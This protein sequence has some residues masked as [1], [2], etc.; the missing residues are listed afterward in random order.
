M[1]NPRP[2]AHPTVQGRCPTCRRESLFL[3]AGG[4]VTCRRLECPQPM[5]ATALLERTNAPSKQPAAAVDWS[6]VTLN[7]KRL[8]VLPAPDP[9]APLRAVA[10]AALG[11]ADATAEHRRSPQTAADASGPDAPRAAPDAR[12]SA[13]HPLAGVGQRPEGEIGAHAG[14]QSPGPDTCRARLVNYHAQWACDRPAGHPGGHSAGDRG[15]GAYQAWTDQAAGAAVGGAL[16]DQIAEAL[17]TTPTKLLDNPAEQRGP[18]LMHVHGSGHSYDM[19]CALCRGEA[20]TLADAVLPVIEQHT[21]RLRSRAA[22]AEAQAELTRGELVNTRRDAR[23]AQAELRRV[24]TL[25]AD[26]ERQLRTDLADEVQKREAAE[27]RLGSVRD[28]A[29]DL[30]GITGARHIANALDKILNPKETEPMP[31]TPTCNATIT[32]PHVPGDEPVQCTRDAG[33]PDPKSGPADLHAAPNPDG[34]GGWLRWTDHHA[35]ATPH[36]NTPKEN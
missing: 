34:T 13:E 33:H 7:V 4:Y 15:S 17:R 30:R 12:V 22:E 32:G 20:D 18:S 6:K 19:T 24:R 23:A 1:N 3:G 5:A 31:D 29:A 26:T 9:A 8:G 11:D 10:A 28:L 14:T 21:A 2:T 16:R 36:T 35:G 25:H 27:Q